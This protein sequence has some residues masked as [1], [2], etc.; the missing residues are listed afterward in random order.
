VGT[1]EVEVSARGG[2]QRDGELLEEGEDEESRDRTQ[3]CVYYE[4]IGED[5][6][7]KSM[8]L[9]RGEGILVS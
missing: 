1:G 2:A 9:L 4:V 7:A 8:F 5:G 3:D 6:Y